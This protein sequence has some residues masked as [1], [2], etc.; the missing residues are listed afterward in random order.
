MSRLTSVVVALLA[1]CCVLPG[2]ALPAMASPDLDRSPF[3]LGTD[4][5]VRIWSLGID[6][7]TD[8]PFRIDPG[9]DL[10]LPVAGKVH[11]EGLTVEQLRAE[12]MRRFSKE[13]RNPQVSV[14]ILEFGS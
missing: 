5:Q 13:V 4:D 10:D 3:V 11:A 2:Q 12:L 1:G 14:E 6:E 8:K 9:G 7:I